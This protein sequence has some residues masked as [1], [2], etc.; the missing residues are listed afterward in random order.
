MSCPLKYILRLFWSNKTGNIFYSRLLFYCYQPLQIF[1]QRWHSW[2]TCESLTVRTVL[3]NY[4]IITNMSLDKVFMSWDNNSI[5]TCVSLKST[6]NSFKIFSYFYWCMLRMISI[7]YSICCQYEK[8]ISI[9]PCEVFMTEIVCKIIP[10]IRPHSN[11][12][13]RFKI[14]KEISK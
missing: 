13:M 3:R 6:I 12:N 1:D 10:E 7:K 14:N 11:I 5:W 2:I 4:Q 8:K 9:I